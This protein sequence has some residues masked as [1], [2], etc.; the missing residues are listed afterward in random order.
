MTKSHAKAKAA[1]NRGDL[2]AFADSMVDAVEQETAMHDHLNN[3]IYFAQIAYN[4]GPADGASGKIIA[5]GPLQGARRNYYPV[6]YPKTKG[7][8]REVKADA[9]S[10]KH[11]LRFDPED[12]QAG[13]TWEDGMVMVRL[14]AFKEARKDRNPGVLAA[15]LQHEAV[16][17]NDLV[18]TGWHTTEENELHAY[19]EALKTAAVFELD[20]ERVDFIQKTKNRHARRIWLN[21]YVP[22]GPSLHRPF[23]DAAQEKENRRIYEFEQAHK[24]EFELDKEKLLEIQDIRLK[25]ARQKRTAA[26]LEEES[27][28]SAMASCRQEMR[29]IV[30]R[31]CEEFDYE[32]FERFRSARKHCETLESQP[33]TILTP[34]AV[35]VPAGGCE[36]DLW[37]ELEKHPGAS[38][39]DLVFLVRESLSDKASRCSSAMK[40]IAETACDGGGRLSENELGSFYKNRY[41]VDELRSFYADIHP[42]P[43]GGDC[44]EEL[45]AELRKGRY[46]PDD[47]AE[48]ARWVWQKYNPPET[49]SDVTPP[50]NDDPDPPTKGPEGPVI[51]LPKDPN[52][53]G[54]R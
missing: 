5:N 54:R 32:G 44:S 23:P 35:P 38:S 50:T 2:S 21:A 17:F 28:Q 10:E 25:A 19:E 36:G 40:R 16:H 4:V 31:E 7:T 52:W 12:T 33:W 14:Q 42:V 41:C 13:G 20:K 51:R 26:R 6:F 43:V 46:A 47:A 45:E 30:R 18:T 29:D 39:D 48:L 27:R 8:T 11:Y 22:L 34:V 24:S 3:A 9:R 53:D 37:R 1:K 49:P 15:L